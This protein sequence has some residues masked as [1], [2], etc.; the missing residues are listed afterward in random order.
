MT[1]ELRRDAALAA[2]AALAAAAEFAIATATDSAG[3]RNAAAAAGLVLAASSVALRRRDPRLCWIIAL[4]GFM[5]FVLAG[6]REAEPVVQAMKQLDAEMVLQIADLVADGAG[7]DIQLQRRFRHA[8][9]ATRRFEGPEGVQR[10][11]P[12]RHRWLPQQFRIPKES[13]EN[14]SVVALHNMAHLLP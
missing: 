10:R 8:E 1:R 9:M 3:D 5:L 7:A 4:T 11:Q 13:F 14:V 12:L 2:V 6:R